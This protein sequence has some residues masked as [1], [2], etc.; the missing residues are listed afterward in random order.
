MT[1]GLCRGV[2][3]VLRQ[4][5]HRGVM[6]VTGAKHL[7]RPDVEGGVQAPGCLPPAR[8]RPSDLLLTFLEGL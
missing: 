8:F 1:Y 3:F 4:K 7:A 2:P 5:L 6:I